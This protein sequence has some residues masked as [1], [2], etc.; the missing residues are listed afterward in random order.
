VSWVTA[1]G[2]SRG[3]NG[4]ERLHGRWCIMGMQRVHLRAQMLLLS[5]GSGKRE[6]KM[7][8]SSPPMYLPSGG[9]PTPW[10]SPLII[11][12]GPES[13]YPPRTIQ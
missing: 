1:V 10:V 3:Q 11:L 9:S 8:R 7:N 2:G 4:W 13:S 12:H 6:V 5:V